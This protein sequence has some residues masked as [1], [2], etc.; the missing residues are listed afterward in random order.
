MKNI[1]FYKLIIFDFDGVIVENQPRRGELIKHV[2]I[3]IT[4]LRYFGFFKKITDPVINRI[5]ENKFDEIKPIYRTV[6]IIKSLSAKKAI[7]SLNSHEI[8]DRL[9]EKYDLENQFDII[10]G[11]EDVKCPKPL[12]EGINKIIEKMNIQKTDTVFIGDLWTD[13]LAAFFS[14]IDY[15][16]IKDLNVDER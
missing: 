8:I 5:M 9:L 11:I 14:Y 10:L 3:S 2:G 7:C 13:R 6:E 12:P 15:L 1:K 4:T 16:D